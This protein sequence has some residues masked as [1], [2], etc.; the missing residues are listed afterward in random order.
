MSAT[1]CFHA[2]R[3]RG[4]PLP[5]QLSPVQERVPHSRSSVFFFCWSDVQGRLCWGGGRPPTHFLKMV[6]IGP[7]GR[8]R[9]LPFEQSNF[10]NLYRVNAPL[11]FSYEK[12]R[13]VA[14]CAHRPFSQHAGLR[15]YHRQAGTSVSLSPRAG[16]FDGPR[17]DFL[18]G[19]V[20]SLP[21]SQQKSRPVRGP[22]KFE[23]WP[24]KQHCHYG[25][26]FWQLPPLARYLHPHHI[27]SRVTCTFSPSIYSEASLYLGVVVILW[28]VKFPLGM[29]GGV[30]QYLRKGGR[31]NRYQSTGIR[32]FPSL[33]RGL[34]RGI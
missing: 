29:S 18:A 16:R 34:G 8:P 25:D 22:N 13:V 21:G 2:P 23:K 19:G 10:V 5:R 33:F 7:L 24:E 12:D 6:E 17:T 20:A 1:G 4:S 9:S 28:H 11:F 32:S 15:Q 31:A 14:R 3:R 27:S 26:I 30:V